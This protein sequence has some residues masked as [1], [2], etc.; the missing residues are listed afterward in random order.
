MN[1]YVYVKHPR[2]FTVHVVADG[3]RALGA[4]AHTLCGLPVRWHLYEVGDETVSGVSATCRRC[5]KLA[6][7][8]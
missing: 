5:R 1:T 6:G 4:D 7:A 2:T 3:V 8:A